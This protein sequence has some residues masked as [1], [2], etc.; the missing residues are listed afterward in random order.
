MEGY[1]IRLG[2][3]VSIDSTPF[4]GKPNDRDA[5]Y[6]PH[7]KV[8]GY[9]IHG[10][11]DADH[12]LPLAFN[13][14]TITEGDCP[15]YLPLLVRLNMLGIEFEKVLAD[16]AYASLENFAVANHHYKAR[17]VF[18]LREN[19]IIKKAGTK[20][21]VDKEYNKLWM[22]GGFDP[23]AGHEYKLS[24]LMLSNIL[25]LASSL[26]SPRIALA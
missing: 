24:F 11:I 22:E 19:T 4:T 18:H 21:G 7:Y 2:K 15:H 1:G 12:Y 17:T 20:K 9:K 5:S 10:V 23:D 6:N 26:G 16:G 3:N 13:F 14:T 25:S 8:W